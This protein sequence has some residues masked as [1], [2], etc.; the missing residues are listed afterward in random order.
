[1][2]LAERFTTLH[3]M[4]KSFSPE[5]RRRLAEKVGTEPAM[6]YQAIT[7]RGSPFSPAR[8]VEI[9][10]ASDKELRRWDL[11]PKD[12]HRIWP[13]LIGLDGAPEV[14]QEP[15]RQTA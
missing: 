7:G 8:C 11:R 14:P 2:T 5:D 10:A 6:L 13:E 4:S 12:W 3:G 15:E 1:L 9:E